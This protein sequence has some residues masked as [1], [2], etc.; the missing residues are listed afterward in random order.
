MATQERGQ[1]CPNYS[2]IW[3]SFATVGVGTA[4]LKATIY[5]HTIFTRFLVTLAASGQVQY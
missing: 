4:L 1:S 3:C 5:M 2:K